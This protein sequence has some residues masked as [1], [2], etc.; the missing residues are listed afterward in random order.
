MFVTL[1]QYIMIMVPYLR[2][3][4]FFF[5]IVSQSIVP[6][7]GLHQTPPESFPVVFAVF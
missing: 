3:V 6:P 7:Q 2:E 5:V 4:H 1:R